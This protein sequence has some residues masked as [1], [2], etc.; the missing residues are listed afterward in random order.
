MTP[1]RPE[2]ASVS[3]DLVPSHPAW[4]ELTLG[5]TSTQLAQ[6][7]QHGE[8]ELQPSPV[9]EDIAHEPELPSEADS[10]QGESHD[11]SKAPGSQKVS[12]RS[13][14][15]RRALGWDGIIH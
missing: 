1:S 14:R 8:G 7:H 3:V 15:L 11:G 13:L 2:A 10:E 12:A 5:L 4:A 6:K 9:P